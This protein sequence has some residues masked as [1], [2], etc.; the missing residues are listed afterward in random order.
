M[1]LSGLWRK[2]L[3]K[4]RSSRRTRQSKIVISYRGRKTMIFFGTETPWQKKNMRG[5]RDLTTHF[6]VFF[7]LGLTTLSWSWWCISISWL[8]SWYHSSL[9][10]SVVV[11]FYP[12]RRKND[13]KLMEIFPLEGNIC[14]FGL[15]VRKWL[16]IF[17]EVVL[18]SSGMTITSPT[19]MQRMLAQ[20]HHLVS[21]HFIIINYHIMIV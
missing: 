12:F 4:E 2:L 11:W 21:S 3:E 6:D 13:T 8:P 17:L 18:A 20:W 19:H 10:S 5:L 16:G 9:E 7:H 1:W 15:F 14:T